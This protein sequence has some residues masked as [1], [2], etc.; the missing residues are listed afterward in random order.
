[1][2]IWFMSFLIIFRVTMVGHWLFKPKSIRL[3]GLRLA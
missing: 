1:L 3:R 2:D